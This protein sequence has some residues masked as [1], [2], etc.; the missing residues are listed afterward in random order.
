MTG[1]AS[2][3]AAA[4]ALAAA[5]ASRMVPAGPFQRLNRYK[6]LRYGDHFGGG[7][8]LGLCRLGLRGSPGPCTAC[9]GAG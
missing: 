5:T 1:R 6:L 7:T 2:Y 8:R 4:S 3:C 9:D